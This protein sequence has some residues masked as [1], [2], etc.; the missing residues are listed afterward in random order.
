[1]AQATVLA[2]GTTAAQSSDIVVLQGQPVTVGIF[3]AA[4]LP[5]TTRC[6]ISIKGPTG[7]QVVG[8]LNGDT[9]ATT[10]TAAG[11]YFVTRPALTVAAGVFTEGA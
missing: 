10:I 11:T 4:P 7:S 2:S 5:A 3:S 6:A 9:V 8:W 1:M